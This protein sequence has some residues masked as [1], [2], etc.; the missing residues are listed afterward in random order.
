MGEGGTVGVRDRLHRS[1]ANPSGPDRKIHCKGRGGQRRYSCEGL[2]LV[3]HMKWKRGTD[4]EGI[5]VLAFST[6]ARAH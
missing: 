6:G 1:N 2:I 3:E 5:G 4:G